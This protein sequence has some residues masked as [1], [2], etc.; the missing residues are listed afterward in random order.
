MSN[1]GPTAVE[2]IPSL[3]QIMK[4]HNSSSTTYEAAADCLVKIGTP[5][6]PLLLKIAEPTDPPFAGQADAILGLGRFPHEARVVVPVLA[7][8]LADE[9]YSRCAV[10]A[11]G[12]LGRRAQE[13]SLALLL[14]GFTGRDSETRYYAVWAYRQTSSD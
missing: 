10:I 6:L 3:G 9:Y 4:A 12:K 5:A 8:R 2:A 7:R 11:L 13:A 1:Y 14:M